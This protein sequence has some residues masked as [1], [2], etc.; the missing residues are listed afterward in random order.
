MKRFLVCGLVFGTALTAGRAGAQTLPKA[1]GYNVNRFEPS[2]RGSEWFANES[3]DLRGHLRAA[4]GVVGDYQ[5]RPLVFYYGEKDG[6]G[7][8]NSVV[9]NQLNAHAGA[10]FMLFDRLRLAASIP[11]VA[12]TDGRGGDFSGRNYAAPPKEQGIGDLRLGVDARILGTYGDPFQLAAGLQFWA[13]TGDKE[14]YTSD[15]KIRM[16][17]RLMASGDIGMLTYAAKLG[18]HYRGRSESFADGQIGSEIIFSGAAGARVSKTIV[19]GPELYGST[20]TDNVFSKQG[21][22]LEALLGAHAG[23]GDVRVGGGIG[24]GLIR[25]FGSPEVRALLSVEFFPTVVVDTDAD[26]VPDSEDACKE[27]RGVRTTDPA[28]NGC[29]PPPPPP[30]DRDGDGVIDAQ[31]ACPDVPGVASAD[32]TQNGCPADRDKDGILDREDACPDEPGLKSND[33]LTNGCADKDGDGVFD[34]DDACKDVPGLKT[35]DPKTNGCPDT[36]RDKDGILNDVDACPDVAGEANADPKKN[37]CPKAEIKDGQVKILDQIRFKTGKAEIEGKDSEEVLLAVQ[38]ILTDH[39]EIKKLR[40]EGY[41]DNVGNAAL[42]KKLSADRAAAVVKWLTGKGIDKARL[43]SAGFGPDKPIGDNKTDEGKRLNRRVE[44]HI[45]GG[46]DTVKEAPKAGG[47]A[48]PKEAPKP[49][50]TGAGQH[51]GGG[52]GAHT[53]GGGG[54]GNGGG[55][56]GA[57]APKK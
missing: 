30:P 6:G 8:R 54:K 52:A 33:P 53:G 48:A 28:T 36:D 46:P 2:E 21:T 10:S 26:G 22:P 42:N 5:Y 9:R 4:A 37:G 24:T 38:K 23:I 47:T 11:I 16:A 57:P 17:P 45:D 49:A 35:T 20:T 55:K 44:F 27:V 18:F 39:P 51:K 14:L 41:T 13:P 40:V 15:G 34:K 43:T 7:V 50:A 12:F 3:L 1:E 56:G 31:D 25:G 29:P 32:S 19:V